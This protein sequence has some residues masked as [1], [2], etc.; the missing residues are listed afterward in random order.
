MPPQSAL[1]PLDGIR[2]VELA[3]L[4]PG[5]CPLSFFSFTVHPSLIPKLFFLQGPFAS[6]ILADYGASVLRI[7]R[8]HPDAHSSNSLPPPTNDLLTRCKSSIAVDLKSA[9]GLLLVKHL[10]NHVDVL[11]DPFRPGV[12][13]SLS[14]IPAHLLASNPRLIIARLTGFRQ[15]DDE[16]S[17]QA[18]HDI[19]YLALSGVL[20]H[21]RRRDQ[22][23]HAPS[24]F[25]ADFA[26]GGLLCAF[27]VLLA[28]LYRAQTGTGQVVENSMVDGSAYVASMMRYNLKFPLWDNRPGENL[29]DGGCPWYD[30]YECK[31][32]GYIAVGALEPK[33]F[34]ELL[35]GLAIKEDLL[36]RRE[37]RTLWPDMRKAFRKRFLDK[38]RSE[39]EAIFSGKDACC[40]PVRSQAE[41]Q[42]NGFVQRLPIDLK[43]SPGRAIS[44]QDGWDSQGLA[45]GAGGED[46]LGEWTG[47]KRGR[48]YVVERGGLVQIN[49]AKL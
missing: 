36:D 37:D 22:L 25:L 8:P 5:A 7:D 26:G 6:L 39:W 9:N 3:G 44:P 17:R 1:A 4:A 21:L 48:N 15:D 34:V 14:L 46:L 47:W 38:T 27:G 33:F 13:E 23:P 30:V 41:L 42:A 12:L 2:L 40:T 49:L 18:E 31:G 19:N 28:I 20:Y 32:G 10:L 45:P 16:Y 35:R 11:I 43:K 29:L 24:N